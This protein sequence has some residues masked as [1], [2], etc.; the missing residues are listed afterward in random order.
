[1]LM[2]AR[3]RPDLDPGLLLKR[4][5]M[6]LDEKAALGG[7]HCWEDRPA[8]HWLSCSGL[9]RR[10]GLKYIEE[11]GWDMRVCLGHPT[12]DRLY[13]DKIDIIRRN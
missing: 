9:C 10:E 1:M 2:E 8:R 3:S 7:G 13:K 4:P 5:P 6:T 12:V 11:M